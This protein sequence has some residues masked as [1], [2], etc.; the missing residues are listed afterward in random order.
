MGK[1]KSKKKVKKSCC[2]KYLKKG[3]HCSKCPALVKE[4]CKLK[5]EEKAAAKKAKKK[6]KKKKKN[7][8]KNS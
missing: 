6:D 4:A 5:T 3:R 7:K 8:K 1:K 2:G